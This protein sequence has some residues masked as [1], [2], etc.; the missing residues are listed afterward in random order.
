M[1]KSN[2]PYIFGVCGVKNSGK[3]TYMEKLIKAL[4]ARGLTVAAIKHDGHDFEGDIA[5]TDSRRMYDAG[6]DAT[7]VFS[8]GQLL[9]HEKRETSLEEL[10]AY[11]TGYDIVLVEGM[12]ELHIDKVEIV[13]SGNSRTPVSNPE[14]RMGIVTDIE[15]SEAALIFGNETIYPLNDV[16]G[17]VCDVLHRLT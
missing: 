10:Y 5:G 4:K 3:T 8:Q 6:A 14:G 9:I 16:Q 1:W 12:K 11:F 7:A 15:E 13:R 2:K 17:L